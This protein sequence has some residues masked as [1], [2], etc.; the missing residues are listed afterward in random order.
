MFKILLAFALSVLFS[1]IATA[2]ANFI[3]GIAISRN[4]IN[5]ELFLQIQT[6]YIVTLDIHSIEKLGPE[7]TTEDRNY[8]TL[9]RPHSTIIVHH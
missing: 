8:F 9:K 1:T 2:N 4:I 6:P 5:G 3:E 7:T